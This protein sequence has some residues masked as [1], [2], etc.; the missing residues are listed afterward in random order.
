MC[1]SGSV[2]Q[3]LV[4]QERWSLARGVAQA[5]D[6]CTTLK[7]QDVPSG[8]K[9]AVA[10]PVAD[11]INHPLQLLW[12]TAGVINIILREDTRFITLSAPLILPRTLI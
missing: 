9:A 8:L 10:L 11:A 2:L 5:R 3:N 7:R 6:Y 12:T 1:Y 4:A